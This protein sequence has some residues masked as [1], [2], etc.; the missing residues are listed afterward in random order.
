M[1][2]LEDQ[3][4]PADDQCGAW[5]DKFGEVTNMGF[6]ETNLLI[7]Q[8]GPVDVQNRAFR[9]QYGATNFGP[10]RIYRG[11]QMTNMG[12]HEGANMGCILTYMG[13]TWGL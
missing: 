12:D 2:D 8:I 10:G 6:E 5:E 11:L 7:T 13:L 3:I 9:N 1:L 4:G